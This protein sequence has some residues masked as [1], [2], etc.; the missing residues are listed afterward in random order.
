MTQDTKARFE[1]QVKRADALNARRTRVQVQLEAARQQHAQAVREAIEAYGTAD[2]N[3]L[4]AQH[5]ALA[6]ENTRVVGDFEAAL[7][8]FDSMLTRIEAALA[9]PAALSDFL[10]ELGS[11]PGAGSAPAGVAEVAPVAAPAAPVFN[12]A[13]I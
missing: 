11:T 1:Q 9:D 10:L 3:V 4:R 2:L 12:D 7:G 8:T 13:D 5:T 6:E